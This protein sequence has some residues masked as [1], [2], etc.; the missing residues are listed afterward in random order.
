LP[1]PVVMPIDVGPVGGVGALEGELP[2]LWVAA[3]APPA[4]P[5]PR[6]AKIAISFPWP[7]VSPI[8]AP[9]G[10][11]EN[12][13]MMVLVLRPRYDTLTN[14]GTLPGIALILRP[15]AA[16]WPRLSVVTVRVLEPLGNSPVAPSVGRVKTATAPEMGFCFSSS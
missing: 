3:T 8:L 15:V 13:V 12:W 16:A 4:A 5:A 11:T 7:F 14:M 6:I 10:A 1:D 9:G 2:L